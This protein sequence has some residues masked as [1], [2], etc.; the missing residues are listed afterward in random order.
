MSST[1]LILRPRDMA[2]SQNFIYATRFEEQEHQQWE[3]DAVIWVVKA[4]P[5]VRKSKGRSWTVWLEPEFY[6]SKR[7]YGSPVIDW[8]EGFEQ[9]RR[10]SGFCEGRPMV[11]FCIRVPLCVGLNLPRRLV[12]G[13]YHPLNWPFTVPASYSNH[14][15]I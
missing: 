4:S 14:F 3:S 7:Q 2:L 11:E 9:R 6:E 10:N 15:L 13:L 8:I 5:E 1:A 12:S